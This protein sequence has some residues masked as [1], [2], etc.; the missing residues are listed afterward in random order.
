MIEMASLRMGRDRSGEEVNPV[1][2]GHWV[3]SD[4]AMLKRFV[5]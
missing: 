4:A 3:R 1:R 2:A 5:S